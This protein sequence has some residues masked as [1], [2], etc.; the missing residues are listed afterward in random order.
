MKLQR[1]WRQLECLL[2]YGMIKE[3]FFQK[4]SVTFFIEEFE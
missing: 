3:M 2:R 4:V 1:Q